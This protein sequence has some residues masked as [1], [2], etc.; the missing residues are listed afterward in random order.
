MDEKIKIRKLT[1]QDISVC[2]KIV[3]QTGVSSGRKEAKKI[4]ELSLAKGIKFLNPEYYVLKLN[5]KIVGISGLYYDYEDPLNVM[6]LDYLAVLQEFQNKGLGTMLLDNL[7][8]V[9]K[10]KNVK[11]LCVFTDRNPAVIFYQKMGF[12]VCG[13]IKNYYREN[14]SK[15]WLYKKI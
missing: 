10:K 14:K 3:L 9:A 1:K 2:L 13:E 5:D 4:M 6:W 11:M 12:E 7:V 15:I 8:K